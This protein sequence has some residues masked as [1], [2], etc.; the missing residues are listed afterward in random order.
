MKRIV[1]LAVPTLLALSA[2]SQAPTASSVALPDIPF[3]ADAKLSYNSIGFSAE[4]TRTA[5]GKWE[6]TVTEPYPLEGLKTELCGD[7]TRVTMYGLEASA[8][9]CDNAV[10][11]AK[12]I[13]SAYDAAVK[14]S[15]SFTATDDGYTMSGTCPLGEFSVVLD[16]DGIPLAFSCDAADLSVE[17]S[18]FEELPKTEIVAEIVE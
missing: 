1:L 8:D 6:L 11:A 10:S 2:C 15:G 14:S 12:A 16:K 3:R 5:A 7:E 4:I 9:T 17:L 18:G 13:A